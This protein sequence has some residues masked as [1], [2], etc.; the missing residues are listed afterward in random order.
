MVNYVL[1]SIKIVINLK[2][3][4]PSSKSFHSLN[5]VSND[6]EDGSNINTFFHQHQ[7]NDHDLLYYSDDEDSECTSEN[8]VDENLSS[9]DSEEEED[10][11]DKNRRSSSSSSKN[12]ISLSD[13]SEDD[14]DFDE[15][16]SKRRKTGK[17]IYEFQNSGKDVD[18]EELSSDQLKVK[19]IFPIFRDDLDWKDLIRVLRKT[20]RGKR[21]S[22]TK[23]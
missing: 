3:V 14:F 5:T 9:S 22:W 19:I 17:N 8:E 23:E 4:N 2:Q 13:I 10:A 16:P 15:P 11:D 20:V 6:L 12:E 21:Q 7:S 18:D 1:G